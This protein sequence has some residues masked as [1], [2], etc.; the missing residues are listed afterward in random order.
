MEVGTNPWEMIKVGIALFVLSGCSEY[1][2]EYQDF[3][4][5]ELHTTPGENGQGGDDGG[6]DGGGA[7][8]DG[9]DDG[10]NGG[11]SGSGGGNGGGSGS[12]GGN[13]GGS[14]SGGSGSGTKT[15]V[16]VTEYN[17]LSGAW[18]LE[19]DLPLDD[20]LDS[21]VGWIG[22]A[23]DDV[24]QWTSV[25]PIAGAPAWIGDLFCIV[26]EVL[27]KLKHMRVEHSALLTPNG[28]LTWEVAETWK[29][30]IF[31][32]DGEAIEVNMDHFEC[33]FE[34]DKYTGTYLCDNEVHLDNHDV[35]LPVNGI[36]MA[37]L[38]AAACSAMGHTWG[39]SWDA[40][41][42]QTCSGISDWWLQLACYELVDNLVLPD[43]CVDPLGI[44]LESTSVVS[45]PGGNLHIEGDWDGE[46]LGDSFTGTLEG[47]HR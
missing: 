10:G 19:S 17:E 6:S 43:P 16:C 24:C 29:V 4:T 13:G 37:A 25:G 36:V 45:R 32:P 9:G 30:I 3:P 44:E 15:D 28:D 8:G 47:D 46:L 1:E 40:A 39:C 7:G 33:P 14:G 35:E 42:D 34:V 31:E 12:G 11:G 41:L 22:D 20:A 2:Y 18:D 27:G 26:D 5:K 21:W 38:D 23:A